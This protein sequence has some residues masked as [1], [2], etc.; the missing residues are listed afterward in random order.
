MTLTEEKFLESVEKLFVGRVQDT[1]I[2]NNVPK[3]YEK[4]HENVASDLMR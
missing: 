3:P 1:I 4:M 2:Y